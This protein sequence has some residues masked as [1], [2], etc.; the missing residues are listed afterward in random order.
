MCLITCLLLLQQPNADKSLIHSSTLT[1]LLTSH[2]L[3]HGTAVTCAVWAIGGSEQLVTASL[4]QMTV[5]LFTVEA[6]PPDG[7]VREV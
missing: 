1:L 3:L 5:C 7:S 2:V 6:P 4:I